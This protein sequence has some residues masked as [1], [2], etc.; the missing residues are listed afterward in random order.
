MALFTYDDGSR[1]E[2]LLSVLKDLSPN[3]NNYL[4]TKLGVSS[5]DNTLHEWTVRRIARPSATNFAAEGAQFS[6]PAGD[7]P[8]RSNNITAGIVQW[9]SVSGTEEAVDRATRGSALDDE[10]KVKLQRLKAD[11]EFAL[12]RGAK[13]SGASGTARG[14][15]GLVGVISTNLTARSSGTSMS[16]TELED[17]HQNSWDAVDPDFVADILLVPMGIKRKIATFTTRVT[18]YQQDT[19]TTYA[20]IM[21]Y[22]TSSGVLKIIPHKDVNNAAGTTAVI[23][24]NSGLYRMAFLKGREP[25]YTDLGKT[26]DDIRGMYV[27]ELTLESLGEAAS[28]HR[29]GYNQNG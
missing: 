11:M 7:A 25:K 10:K 18:S 14:M 2:S 15:A 24:M 26:G 8:A 12:I 5:A 4:V 20:N 6:Q 22:E 16:T 17:I 1:R 21:N 27:T 3:A 29:T 23:A 9:V 19:N 28:V 13:A